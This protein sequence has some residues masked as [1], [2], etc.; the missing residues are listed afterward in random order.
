MYMY[1][2]IVT[3]CVCKFMYTDVIVKT[4]SR[5]VLLV[6]C[7]KKKCSVSID[8][9]WLFFF[10][11]FS[12]QLLNCTLKSVQMPD[13]ESSPLFPALLLEAALLH[14]SFA[15][16]SNFWSRA[17]PQRMW[18]QH[19]VRQFSNHSD[20]NFPKTLKQNL[21]LKAHSW[22]LH[23]GDAGDMLPFLTAVSL[24]N[25]LL[26]QRACNNLLLLHAVIHHFCFCAA[27]MCSKHGSEKSA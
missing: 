4:V 9:S 13:S 19:S 10:F 8:P 23:K 1:I 21:L 11:L 14:S 12:S 15:I 2:Y 18:L 24:E 7:S 22:P 26:G 16:F 6:C 17:V 27:E 25:F 5:S 3:P 20:I